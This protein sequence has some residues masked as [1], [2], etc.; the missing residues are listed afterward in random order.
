MGCVCELFKLPIVQKYEEEGRPDE[1][2]PLVHWSCQ[3]ALEKAEEA[4]AEFIP[5]YVDY[6]A[7]QGHKMPFFLKQLN[8]SI[9]VKKTLPKGRVLS[10]PSDEL[11]RKAADIV[12][13]PGET[14]DRLT[15]DLFI[16]VLQ[17]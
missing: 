1:D 10:K 17:L 14:R 16:L 15:E 12:L 9:D 4:L 3:W 13:S 6:L 11:A 2:L 7:E 8:K 5:N